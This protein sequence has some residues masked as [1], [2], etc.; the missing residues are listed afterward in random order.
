[1]VHLDVEFGSPLGTQSHSISKPHFG[2]SDAKVT[3]RSWVGMRSEGA[4][5]L[6]VQKHHREIWNYDS[7]NVEAVALSFKLWLDCSY[8]E[9]FSSCP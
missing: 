4:S 8:F 7:E 3:F 9:S 1:M 2:A 5:K 6:H